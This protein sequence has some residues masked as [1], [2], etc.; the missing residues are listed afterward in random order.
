MRKL[1][2]SL[3]YPVNIYT[4]HKQTNLIEQGKFDLT[5]QSLQTY[6]HLLQ[7]PDVSLKT[8]NTVN[9]VN[10]VPLPTGGEPHNCETE[11]RWFAKL[12]SDL[13][14]APL[15]SPDLNL[16]V[17]GSCYGDKNGFHA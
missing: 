17:D 5:S 8:C 2:Q 12:Q 9:P 1:Q 16:F 14:G 10:L 6:A 4:H 11:L 13:E 7:Y 15:Q 3:C